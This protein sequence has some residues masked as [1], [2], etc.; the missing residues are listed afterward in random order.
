MRLF[1]V[2]GV[3]AALSCAASAGAGEIVDATGR[4]IKVAEPVTRIVVAGP[5]AEVLL[6]AFA[7]DAMLGWVRKPS[8]KLLPLISPQARALPVVGGVTAQGDNPE[9]SGVLAAKPQLIIDYGDTDARYVAPVKNTQERT[10]I[11]YALIDGSLGKAPQALRDL[12]TLTGR[13]ARGEELAVYAEGMLARAKQAAAG[14]KP[15]KVFVVRSPDGA[16]TAMKDT[17]AGDVY[18][19]AGLVNVAEYREASPP[20][21]AMWDPDVIVTLEPKFMEAAKGA[22]WADVRAI[23]EGRVVSVPRP[24]WGFTDHPPSVNRLI[25]V[26]W[27]TSQFYGAPRAAELRVEAKK[28]HKM[29]FRVDLTEEQVTAMLAGG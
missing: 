12:G 25:G 24:A 13:A 5:P 2:I 26:L 19:L 1:Q 8:D 27:L 4:T 14:K 20:L 17:H 15:V 18:D 21:V 9:V 22:A 23:K 6:Y 16:T 10:G 3:A 28:F 11:P 7:P 29:F